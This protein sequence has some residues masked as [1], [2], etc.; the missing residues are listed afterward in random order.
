M[1]MTNF[2]IAVLVL[3][4]LAAAARFGGGQTETAVAHGAASHGTTQP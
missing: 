4:L 2:G 1:K 3:V